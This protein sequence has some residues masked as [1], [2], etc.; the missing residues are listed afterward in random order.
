MVATWLTGFWDRVGKRL[1]RAHKEARKREGEE[2]ERGDAGHEL[3]NG[4]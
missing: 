4:E 1:Q 3:V 2:E